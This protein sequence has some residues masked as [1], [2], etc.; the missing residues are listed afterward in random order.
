MTYKEILKRIRLATDIFDNKVYL[1]IAKK[2]YSDNDSFFEISESRE[3]T[4]EEIVKTIF[5]FSKMYLEN[6]NEKTHT[7]HNKKQS[8]TISINDWKDLEKDGE[9]EK[10]S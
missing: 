9:N 2:E 4:K 6:N 1:A 3:I 8:I 5:Q 10:E 7:F